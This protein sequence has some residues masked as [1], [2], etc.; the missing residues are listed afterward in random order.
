MTPESLPIASSAPGI[1][2]T[3]GAFDGAAAPRGGLGET[4][5]FP[6]RARLPD[7]AVDLERRDLG[8]EVLW[9]AQLLALAGWPDAA[10]DRLDEAL[11]L[12][13]A[14]GDDALL[15]LIQL[16]RS[17]VLETQGRDADA[18]VIR[19]EM[20]IFGQRH[21]FA[22]DWPARPDEAERAAT[23][24]PRLDD[25][26]L[27]GPRTATTSRRLRVVPVGPDAAEDA[28]APIRIRT[29]GAFSVLVRGQPFARGRKTPH[30]PLALLQALVALGGNS[31]AATVIV[32]ALWPDAD[33]GCGR[34]ALDVALLR[35]RR[36]LGHEDVVLVSGGRLTLNHDICWV[37]AWAF[38]RAVE[39]VENLD[40]RPSPEQLHEVAD[41]ILS[42]YQGRFLGAEED[43][44]WMMPARD[45]LAARFARAIATC[46]RALAI[47]GA[48]IEA[49][50]LYRRGLELDNLSEPLY[51]GLMECCTAQGHRSEA[52]STYRRC[53]ELLS[54]VLNTRPSEE[55][56]ALYRRLNAD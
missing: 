16:A 35:L 44:P 27:T 21:G 50:A 18:D 8:M 54:I 30:K 43:K 15:V 3:L 23:V 26:E 34:R 45:R 51:R 48:P 9:R 24:A 10:L 52:I 49:E 22:D 28:E 7:G 36:L 47:A 4:L 2:A 56:E 17:R 6:E 53:R 19:R 5:R 11:L 37:D 13:R 33:G 32:D 39:A 31:V 40:P 12:A 42:L 1:A 38:D 55:T 20:M 25:I 29:L 46:A 14:A 41:N